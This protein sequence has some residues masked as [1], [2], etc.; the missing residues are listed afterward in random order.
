MSFE[1][2]QCDLICKIKHL[3]FPIRDSCTQ[4]GFIGRKN[5]FDVQ[6]FMTDDLICYTIIRLKGQIPCPLLYKKT[7]I[8]SEAP[9]SSVFLKS[10]AHFPGKLTRRSRRLRSRW[11][12]APCISAGRPRSSS[13]PPVCEN[14]LW[15][16]NPSLQSPWRSFLSISSRAFSR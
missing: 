14:P 5:T 11:T 12:A 16:G 7:D 13:G 4:G 6:Y 8:N 3:N 9:S 15:R 2:R 1:T 10:C